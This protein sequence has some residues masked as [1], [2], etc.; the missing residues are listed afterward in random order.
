MTIAAR[1]VAAATTVGAVVD[2]PRATRVLQIGGVARVAGATR[3]AVAAVGATDATRPVY[4]PV[5]ATQSGSMPVRWC[6]QK[7]ERPRTG[8]RQVGATTRPFPPWTVVALTGRRPR[9][10]QAP[11]P[12]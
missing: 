1:A 2:G 3:M 12:S 5:V 8:P 9:I 6:H 11:C 7:V 4:R 10:R